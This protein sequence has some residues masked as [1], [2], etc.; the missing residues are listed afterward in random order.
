M[1]LSGAQKSQRAFPHLLPF[2]HFD[3]K[4]RSPIS[5]WKGACTLLALSLC[6]CHLRDRPPDYLVLIDNW[7]CIYKSLRP[8][9]DKEATGMPMILAMAMPSGLSREW[10]G[11]NAYFLIF[12]WKG[13]NYILF[14]RVWFLIS[15]FSCCYPSQSSRDNDP[16]HIISLWLTPKIKPRCQYLPWKKPVHTASISTFTAAIQSLGSQITLLW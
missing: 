1:T 7:I 6:C 15:S 4:N 12:L 16:S 13:S 11:K 14:M 2:V 8:V 5:F 10:A 3:N 9:A